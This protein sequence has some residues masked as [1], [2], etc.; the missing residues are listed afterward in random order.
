MIVH[1]TDFSKSSEAA[2]TVARSLAR[3]HGV[4]L[5]VL[6]VV[7][8]DIS[9][10]GS[11]TMARDPR[12]YQ[13]SLDAIRRRLD[14]PDLKYPVETQ[15]KYG[16]AA[17]EIVRV[18]HDVRCNLIVMG[19]HGRTRLARLLMG[20]TAMAVLPHADCPVLVVRSFQP[21]HDANDSEMDHEQSRNSLP[22]S[23]HSELMKGTQ[24]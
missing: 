14:G 17:E 3:D 5:I 11:P 19:T 1:P 15:L 24:K 22:T 13:H 23:V 21:D 8:L 7:P 10:E 20:N 9:R 2:L 12:E 6:Y 4:Q 18:A 16:S